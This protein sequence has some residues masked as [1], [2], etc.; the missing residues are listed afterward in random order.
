MKP[1]SARELERLILA[2]GWVENTRGGSH[3]N[4]KKAGVEELITIP[5]HK[6]KKLPTGLQLRVMKI[7]GIGK[8]DI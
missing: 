8:D 4:Y 7:A 2:R 3:R 6:G 5:F 1:L